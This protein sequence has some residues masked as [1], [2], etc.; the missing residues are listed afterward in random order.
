VHCRSGNLVNVLDPLV[1]LGKSVGGKSDQLDVAGI[2]LGTELGEGS[3]LG[4]ADGGEVGGV[5]EE[6]T[7]GVTDV[8][9]GRLVKERGEGGG[10]WR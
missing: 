7:P 8:P 9:R 10:K 3:K 6:D 4:G 2:E 5:R 1:V